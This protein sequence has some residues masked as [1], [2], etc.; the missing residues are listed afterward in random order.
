M[1][2]PTLAPTT[3]VRLAVMMFLQFFVWGAYL[4][5]MYKYLGTIFAGNESLDAI[6]G[7]AYATNSIGAILAPFVVGLIADRFLPGQIVMGILHLLG[8]GLLVMAAQATDPG[9]FL[10]GGF[11]GILLAYSIC[12]MP[13][14]A[15]VNS[16]SFDQ[17]ESPEKQFPAIRV[18]GTIGWIVAGVV[19]GT[20][21]PAIGEFPAHEVTGKPD[22]G[23]TNVPFLV[24]AGASA[25]LGL[26]SFTLPNSPPKAKGEKVSLMRLIGLDAVG[27]FKKPAFAV[28]A[29][30]SFLLCIPL[31]VYY[32][33]A[34]DF[35]GAMGIAASETKMTFGQMSEILFMVLMPV[36][37][38]RF[39]VKAMLLGGMAAWILRYFLFSFGVTSEGGIEWMILLGVILHGICYDF[40]FVT[41]HLYTDKTAPREI[42]ASAQ[43][44]IAILTYGVGMFVGNKVWPMVAAAVTPE[45]GEMPWPPFWQA[46]A[47]MALGIAVLFFFT[48]WDRAKLGDKQEVPGVNEG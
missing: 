45:G 28:F 30:C 32:A 13:T 6:I 2:K 23:L 1:S 41:G 39:G 26:Y 15:L 21:L 4:V 14:L 9:G 44:L 34:N 43:G 19:V 18:W 33:R 36:F 3:Y 24:A 48:F 46:F 42:R 47:W 27:M 11:V 10:A 40:F 38:A 37:L 16:V 12:Y 31:A 17:L 29:V 20:V 25:L 22:A 7:D 5:P 35:L 8:A